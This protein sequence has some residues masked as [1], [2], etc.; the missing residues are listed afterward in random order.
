MSP[1]RPVVDDAPATVAGR[2][3]ADGRVAGGRDG[4]R[5]SSARAMSDFH[6][7][8]YVPGTSAVHRIWAGTKLTWFALVSIGLLLWPT[9][10]AVGVGAVMVLG[11]FLVARLP[12]G[13]APRLPRWIWLLVLVGFAIALG[14]SGKPYA[15]LGHVRLGFGGLEQFALFWCITLEVLALALLVSWTTPLA[16]L[17]PAL[18]R[19]G[20]PLRKLR[21]PVD[22][23]VGAIALSI[24]CLPLLLEEGRVLSA[25]RR[26]RRSS[27]KTSP[28]EMAQGLEDLIWAAL[29]NALR[30]ARE[31]AEA[32]EARG[33][34]PTIAR[35]T[36]PFALR[37][38][39]LVALTLA[40]MTA[41]ALLRA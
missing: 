25:A 32:I 12:R 27:A 1:I 11:G 18:G 40:G 37:D 8:R 15:H 5:R 36:H 13:V 17:A 14:A 7:L 33:G 3:R 39:V 20:W 41:M 6:V 34:V 21:L 2:L 31:I 10:K 38:G 9:W 24:R 29:S 4:G 28:K 26:A 35:E 16:D 23:V 19:L 30:R 22:E